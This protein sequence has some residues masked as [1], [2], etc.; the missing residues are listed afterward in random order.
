MSSLRTFYKQLMD[1]AQAAYE[2][3]TVRDFCDQCYGTGVVAFL[4]IDLCDYCTRVELVAYD[5]AR[6]IV[7]FN[8]SL[9]FFIQLP[10]AGHFL[11]CL[12]ADDDQEVL[13]VLQTL[14]HVPE[15]N[16]EWVL[17]KD[18]PKRTE[19]YA[20]LNSPLHS[21]VHMLQRKNI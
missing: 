16:G 5:E 17:W 4:D 20:L 3:Q 6:K 14:L 12:S 18:M 2:W 21:L 8:M 11:S 13:R 9:P 15:D 10:Y 7:S 19:T 1:S